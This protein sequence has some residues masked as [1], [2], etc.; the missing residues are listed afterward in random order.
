MISATIVAP[1]KIQRE[2]GPNL[3]PNAAPSL[4]TSVNRIASPRTSW[5]NWRG[6]S[7]ATAIALVTT[8]STT[9][10]TK[11]PQKIF[12]FELFLSIFL[13]LF[14]GDAEAGVRQRVESLE[15]YLFP[16]LMALS[17]GLRTAIQSP[18]SLIN[19]PQETSFLTREEKGLFPFHGVRPLIRHVKRIRAQVAVRILHRGAE[20]FAVIA[21]LF[22]NAF[23]FL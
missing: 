23:T 7:W 15:C 14:A 11:V 12:A 10:V 5:G 4:N 19:M 9:T 8:S 18:K 13:T 22:Q 17:K 2:N 20:R 6:T 21:E 1:R 3:S 16:A